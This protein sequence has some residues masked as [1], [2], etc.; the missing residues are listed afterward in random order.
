MP[1]NRAAIPRTVSGEAACFDFALLERFQRVR[2]TLGVKGANAEKAYVV[3]N[4]LASA[5]VRIP[6]HPEFFGAVA[7][8]RVEILNLPKGVPLWVLG[9]AKTGTTEARKRSRS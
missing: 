9:E 7:P 5:H 1:D 6:Q 3:Q 8:L 4:G 2:K